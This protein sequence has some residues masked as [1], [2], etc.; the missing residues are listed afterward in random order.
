MRGWSSLFPSFV[1]FGWDLLPLLFHLFDDVY[2]VLLNKQQLCV[3]LIQSCGIPLFLYVVDS[4]EPDFISEAVT[5]L[6]L[7]QL[8]EK[9]SDEE[10]M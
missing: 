5:L 2:S 3:A 10:K 4:F 6:K 7:L 1:R 8:N 9:T